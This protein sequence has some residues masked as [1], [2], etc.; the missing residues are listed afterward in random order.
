MLCAVCLD[1][2]SRRD[3]VLQ[4]WFCEK[5][6]VGS[7]IVLQAKACTNRPLP[8][9]TDGGLFCCLQ[10]AMQVVACAQRRI[11]RNLRGNAETSVE[12]PRLSITYI[13]DALHGNAEVVDGLLF[14]DGITV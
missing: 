3:I 5:P 10:Y 9:C 11:E 1:L 4:A 8:R 2:R 6:N 12:A 14:V 7:E 13:I